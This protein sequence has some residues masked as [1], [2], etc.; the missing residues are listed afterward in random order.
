MGVLALG[1]FPFFSVP[2]SLL[3]FLAV[4]FY[5]TYFNHVII[6]GFEHNYHE[7]KRSR[8]VPPAGY[9]AI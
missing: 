3:P 7:E 8:A 1:L 2:L 4:T 9:V 6:G 5:A